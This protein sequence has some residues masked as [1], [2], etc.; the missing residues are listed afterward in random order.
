M[1]AVWFR[2]PVTDDVEAELPARSLRPTEHL[3]LGRLDDLGH[4]LCHEV[5]LGQPVNRLPHDLRAL[6]D[7]G[8]LD[9]VAIPVIAVLTHGDIEVKIIIDAVAVHL[10]QIKGEP[11]RAQI[12]PRHTAR[13][14]LLRR[15]GRRATNAA[16][17]NLV[18][19]EETVV[20]R[21]EVRHTVDKGA[22]HLRRL[23]REIL[24]Y[25]ANADVVK[26]LTCPADEI[27]ISRIFSRSRKQ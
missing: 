2:R 19:R 21:E 22:D 18:A 12:R 17:K 14:C 5:P 7:L 25:P 16:D 6:R 4:L 10:A 9:H 20:L 24:L 23:G 27:E 3:A 13:E 15:H 1:D 8:E 26:S 11:R